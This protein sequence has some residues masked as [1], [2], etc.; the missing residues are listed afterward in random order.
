MLPNEKALLPNSILL[1]DEFYREYGIEDLGDSRRNFIRDLNAVVLSS[2]VYW[3]Q[4]NE[5]PIQ[6]NEVAYYMGAVFSSLVNQV[7]SYDS[8]NDWLKKTE[9]NLKN[10]TTS[11]ELGIKD[12]LVKLKEVKNANAGVNNEENKV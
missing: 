3:T 1:A 4:T 6:P 8:N 9:E 11:F 2:Y 5:Q 12:K 7:D 10:L